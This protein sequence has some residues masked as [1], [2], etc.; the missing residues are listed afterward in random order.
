MEFTH[1]W[2]AIDVA[3]GIHSPRAIE[4]LERVISS[5]GA[6]VYRRSDSGPESVVPPR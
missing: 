1:E 2:L 3:G 6:P 4:V 5:Y